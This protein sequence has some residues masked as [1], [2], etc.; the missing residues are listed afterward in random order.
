MKEGLK[1]R[2]NGIDLKCVGE[3]NGDWTF[4]HLNEDNDDVIIYSGN[5]LK[6]FKE[7]NMLELLD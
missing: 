1:I 5:D 2:L 7:K 3:F 4:M 6:D